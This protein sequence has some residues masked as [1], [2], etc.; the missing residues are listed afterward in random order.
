MN[1][2]CVALALLSVT[3]VRKCDEFVDVDCVRTLAAPL[4][5]PTTLST[6]VSNSWRTSLMSPL[7]LMVVPVKVPR[8]VAPALTPLRVTRAF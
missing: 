8:V 3:K 7:S 2:S 4:L 6:A 1:D 5:P